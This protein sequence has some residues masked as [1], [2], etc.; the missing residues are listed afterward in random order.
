MKARH[1]LNSSKH[2]ASHEHVLSGCCCSSFHIMNCCNRVLEFRGNCL[3]NIMQICIWPFLSLHL[4]SEYLEFRVKHMSILVK[5]SCAIFSV[6]TWRTSALRGTVSACSSTV[7]ISIRIFLKTCLVPG[8]CFR[9]AALVGGYSDVTLPTF[10][11]FVRRETG[12]NHLFLGSSGLCQ[13][14]KLFF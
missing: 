14:P 6:L 13:A 9:S 1:C 11:Q 7:D 8:L 3:P 4:V 10:P 5:T 2:R 12:G